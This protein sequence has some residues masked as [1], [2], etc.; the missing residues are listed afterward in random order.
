LCLPIET[1]SAA[2]SVI[3]RFSIIGFFRLATVFF[4]AKII[5]RANPKDRTFK[6]EN[7]ELNN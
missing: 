6:K 4:F 7:I 1:P 2:I 3:S 5:K